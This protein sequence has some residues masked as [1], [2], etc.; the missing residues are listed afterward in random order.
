MWN[1]SESKKAVQNEEATVACREQ[2]KQ[3]GMG[4]EC[5]DHPV[6]H[7]HLKSI[8]DHVSVLLM[9]PF[10]QNLLVSIIG[11]LQITIINSCTPL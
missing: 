5:I 7:R 4:G 6:S 9:L 8:Q 3:Y 11:R 1:G 2:R 10:T